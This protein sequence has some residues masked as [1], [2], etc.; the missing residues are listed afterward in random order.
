MFWKDMI[1][2]QMIQNLR[3]LLGTWEGGKC[4]HFK[5]SGTIPLYHQM[6]KL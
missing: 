5:E 4:G 1:A 6:K 2:I 3:E